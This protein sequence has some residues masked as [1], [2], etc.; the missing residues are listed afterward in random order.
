MPLFRNF[1]RALLAAIVLAPV[2]ASAHP[3]EPILTELELRRW[4]NFTEMRGRGIRANGT[5]RQGGFYT[6]SDEGVVTWTPDQGLPVST[7]YITGNAAHL[8]ILRRSVSPERFAQI[9]SIMNPE[10]REE[11]AAEEMRNL[12]Q[13]NPS[14]G[15]ESAHDGIRERFNRL[16][17]T[18][19][20]IPLNE[21]IPAPLVASA[22]AILQ[23]AGLSASSI[24]DYI[25]ANQRDLEPILKETESLEI[26][27][28]RVAVVTGNVDAWFGGDDAQVTEIPLFRRRPKDV[29]DAWNLPLY[30]MVHDNFFDLM[31]QLFGDKRVFHTPWMSLGD[32]NIQAQSQDRR[33]TRNI[34]HDVGVIFN[35]MYDSS[36]WNP[37]TNVSGTWRRPTWLPAVEET[38]R[39]STAELL[40]RLPLPTIDP[41]DALPPV[42]AGTSS[43]SDRASLLSLLRTRPDPRNALPAVPGTPREQE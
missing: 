28:A 35:R 25:D 42:P 17:E 10:A 30:V 15:I 41:R 2:L 9:M 31:E 8:A 24:D 20:A 13:S 14:S 38:P 37:R 21:A 18:L 29:T 11:A 26:I 7:G 12:A 1:H 19:R 40:A 23:E 4:D 3:C 6:F 16:S 39:P 27:Y 33:H 34:Q 43:T 5:P 22:I 36:T 32:G